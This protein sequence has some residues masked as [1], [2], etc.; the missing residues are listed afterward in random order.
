MGGK[1]E[2]TLYIQRSFF[3]NI[4]NYIT[5]TIQICNSNH[6]RSE[7]CTGGCISLN[8]SKFN[9]NYFH[10]SHKT[11][12]FFLSHSLLSVNPSLNLKSKNLILEILAS[13]KSLK[14]SIRAENKGII[15]NFDNDIMKD[16]H[17]KLLAKYKGD[18]KLPDTPLSFTKH[19]SNRLIRLM[20][21][22]DKILKDVKKAVEEGR[23]LDRFGADLKTLQRDIHVKEGSFFN[24][25]K[26]IV[27]AALKSLFLSRFNETHPG[28]FG[29]KSLEEII[30]WPHLYRDWSPWEELYPVYQGG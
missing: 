9:F 3:A 8:L 14:N 7:S 2:L 6:S 21:D 25:N 22:E 19:C 24:D 28:Q 18:L 27:P 16:V 26:L 12:L 29:M 20:T 5:D 10:L 23:P 11:F 13:V 1:K 30:W 17:K 15:L 4:L